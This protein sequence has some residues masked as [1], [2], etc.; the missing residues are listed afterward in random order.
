MQV[1]APSAGTYSPI[2][3]KVQ[4][5]DSPTANLSTDAG[6]TMPAYATEPAEHAGWCLQQRCSGLLPLQMESNIAQ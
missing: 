3:P 5:W 1:I 4:H 2:K 6:T